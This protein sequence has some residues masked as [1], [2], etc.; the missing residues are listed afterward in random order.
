MAPGAASTPKMANN[1]AIGPILSP[2]YLSKYANI[3][4]MHRFTSKWIAPIPDDR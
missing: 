3:I 4:N 2:P 1:V